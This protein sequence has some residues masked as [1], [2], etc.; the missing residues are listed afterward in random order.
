MKNI[1]CICLVVL[2]TSYAGGA[3]RVVTTTQDLEYITK[4]VGGDLVI[5]ESLSTG[6]QDSHLVEPR[7]SMVMKLKKADMVVKIGLDLDM[8]VDSLIAAARNSK[9]V[10]GASGYVDAS[11]GIMLLQVP[12]G[13]IDGSMGDIHI[14][15][16]PHYWLDPDNARIIAESIYKALCLL[17]PENKA[18][19][20]NNYDGFVLEL[21]QRIA[22]WKKQMD[23]LPN[24]K[25]VTY[26]NSWLYFAKAFGLEIIGN[27]E[28]KPGLPPT[29]SHIRG[30]I[31]NMKAKNAKVILIES[32][33]PIK[34]PQL[35][36][37][38]TGAKLI[39]VPCSVGGLPGIKN[40]FDVFDYIINKLTGEI[41]Q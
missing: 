17:S 24:K 25:I 28:P 14:F 10:Y 37:E 13:K 29:P 27:V 34:G 19:F 4:R 11:L 3:V 35:V 22:G 8:W 2:F 41:K 7:P 39:I 18:E 1:I 26:H 20:K 12:K 16:N 9:I 40:Y 31:E 5:T 36:A 6:K 23:A 33:F 38:K 21:E 32:Y 15:G 30:L